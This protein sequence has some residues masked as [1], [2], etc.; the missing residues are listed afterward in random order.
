MMCK[1]A[2]ERWSEKQ[3]SQPIKQKPEEEKFD[4]L[5][6]SRHFETME[7]AMVDQRRK[8]IKKTISHIDG[9]E[10]KNKLSRFGGTMPNGLIGGK[11]DSSLPSG[12]H[13]RSVSLDCLSVEFE[14]FSK[15]IETNRHASVG[16][17]PNLS[18]SQKIWSIHDFDL[19]KQVGLGSFGSVHL[20]IEKGSGRQVA[21]KI[22]KTLRI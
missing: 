12:D 22:L 11:D 5:R 6:F 9:I 8:V 17:I 1:L 13:D 10:Q 4:A 3:K 15:R 16:D 7:M 18:S 20:A 14:R 21:I 2:D 19:R